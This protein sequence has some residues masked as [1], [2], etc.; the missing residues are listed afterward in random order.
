VEIKRKRLKL[1]CE[2]LELERRCATM[3]EK[4][5]T[6]MDHISMVMWHQ[7]VEGLSLGTT[8]REIAVVEQEEEKGVDGDDEDVMAD[9]EGEED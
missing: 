3:E 6:N 4:W 8:W 5:M 7:F 1:E 2:R 9:A